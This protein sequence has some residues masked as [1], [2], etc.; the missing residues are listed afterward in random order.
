MNNLGIKNITISNWVEPDS[1]S[2]S[3][4][5]LSLAGEPVPIVASDLLKMIMKPQL[6][7]AVPDEIQVLF[8]VARGTMVYGWF[9]YPLYTLG[10][11]Q[12]FRVTETAVILKCTKMESPKLI[13]TFAKRIKWLVDREVIL[14]IETNE[15]NALR[16]LRN[17]T[18][19]PEYQSIIMPGMAINLIERTV[20]RINSLFFE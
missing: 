4:G 17:I 2:T 8:E 11:E 20:D 16:K 1:S 10:A 12:L 18:S 14:Q 13:D 19:H 7:S 15:W 9:F 6:R 3:F 5:T